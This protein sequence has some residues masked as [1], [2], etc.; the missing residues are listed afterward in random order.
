[1]E[2]R[3]F[4]KA[5]KEAYPFVERASHPYKI[6]CSECK[7]AR[8]YF[9]LIQSGEVQARFYGQWSLSQLGKRKPQPAAEGQL[10]F[11]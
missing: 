4:N 6:W 8:Q 3:A 10:S 9:A 7:F 1:M 5:L 11:I 2:A